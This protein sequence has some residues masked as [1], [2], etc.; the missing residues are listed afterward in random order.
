MN[1]VDANVLLDAVNEASPQHDVARGWLDRAVTGADTIAFAWLPLAAF[2]RISTRHDLFAT[3]LSVDAAVDQVDAW[4]AAPAAVLVEP[5]SRHTTI[6]RDLLNGAGGAGGIIVNDAHLAALAIEHR[7]GI[8]SFDSDF[9]RF[10]GV[11]WSPPA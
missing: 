6:L 7:A 3:P 9:A 11:A 1:L 5:T 8:V 10:P 2:L 4:L